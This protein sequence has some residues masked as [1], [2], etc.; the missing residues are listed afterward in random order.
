MANQLGDETSPYLLQHADNPVHWYPW[1][2][3]AFEAARRSGRPI[4]LSVGYSACHWCHVMAHESFED[5]ATAEVMNDLF[6]NVKVD[7]EERP[8]IDR[9]YQ[10]AHQLITQRAGGWPLTMFLDPDDQRPFFGG[11]YFPNEARHGMPPFVELLEAVAKYY[12]EE[13]GDAKAQG[14]KIGAILDTLA[15][16]PADDAHLDAEPLDRA[17]AVLG[18]SFDRDFGGFGGAPKFPRPPTLDFLLRSWRASADVDE[19]D[20]ESLYMATLTLKRMADGG[21]FD[22]LGGG[23]YRY[24]VDEYWQIPHFEKM[25]Y[26]N[27]PLLALYAEAWLATG[28]EQ[29]RHPAEATADWL[30]TD[31]QSP[32]GGFYS[33]RDADSEGIEG[34]Y[35]VWRPEEVRSLLTA[36]DYDFASRYYGLDQ[37]ANFEDRWH[38]CLRQAFDEAASAA[39]LSNDEAA[40]ALERV[41]RILLTARGRREPPLR[42]DKQLTAWNALAIRGLAIAGRALERDEL[43]DAA[44]R[45]LVFVQSTLWSDDRLHASYKDGR[46]R[47]NAYL[48]D[49]VFLI[50]AILEYLQARWSTALLDF[51]IDLADRVLERFADPDGG[52]FFT[53]DDHETLMHRSKPLADDALPSGNGVAAYVLQRLGFLLGETRYLDA[54]EATLRSAWRAM[55]Q[56]PHGHVMLLIALGERLTPVESVVIRGDEAEARRWQRAASRIY[57]PGRMVFAIPRAETGLPGALADRAARHGETLAYRCSGTRC[58]LPVD[59]FEALVAGLRSDRSPA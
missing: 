58:E 7:R 53:S 3:A 40:A 10:T 17:R 41:R 9:I 49:H 37:A 34:Q 42:D 32:E 28:D 15:P 33:A 16:P 19:P 43:L 25:L 8:D 11:T 44:H 31:M 39:G 24:S 13:R 5:P 50:D 55:E 45:A 54:A 26:D 23:F 48:D 12:R 56:Y 14:A 20:V 22:H 36:A 29:F 2:D 27:G 18:E 6:V 47:F 30:L 57:A 38:L 59:S 51:A 46:T 35:Y 4:L 1:G 21:L 52:F